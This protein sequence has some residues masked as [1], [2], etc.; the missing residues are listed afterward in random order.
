MFGILTG[1]AV[2]CMAFLGLRESYILMNRIIE[3][4]NDGG[5]MGLIIFL[6]PLLLS[7]FHIIIWAIGFMYFSDSI[8]AIVSEGWHAAILIAVWMPVEG[9]LIRWATE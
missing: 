4:I 3:A 7:Y 6:W 1:G 8:G 5:V 2:M 9:L